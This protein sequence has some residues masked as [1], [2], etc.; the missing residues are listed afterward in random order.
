MNPSARKIKNIIELIEESADLACGNLPET[1][2]TNR[3]YL[4]YNC[5]GSWHEL[6]LFVEKTG[7]QNEEKGLPKKQLLIKISLKDLSDL[8]RKQ[9]DQQIRRYNM[10]Y[11]LIGRTVNNARDHLTHCFKKLYQST[12]A[13]RVTSDEAHTV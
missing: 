9:L 8:E 3:R 12:L 6:W 5:K 2:Q 13:L 1:S 11:F 7:S 10:K 4:Q